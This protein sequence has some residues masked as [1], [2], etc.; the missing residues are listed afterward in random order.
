MNKDFEPRILSI[1]RK[2]YTRKE[3]TKDLIAGA[4][5]GIIS[6]PLA[7]AFAIASGVKPEQGLYTAIVAGFVAA[8]LAGS[9][10]QISGP[11]GAFIVII[12]GIVQK[13]GYDG[14]VIATMLAGVMMIIMGLLRLGSLMKYIPYTLV[15]GF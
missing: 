11:T 6:L 8:L 14:L 5:V 3:F 12:F 10:F 15:I 2:D 13:Y 4:I 1:F 9:R 7:I